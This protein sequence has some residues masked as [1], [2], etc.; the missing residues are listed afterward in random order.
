MKLIRVAVDNRNAKGEENCAILQP[1]SRILILECPPGEE[2]ENQ[3]YERVSEL[4][5]TQK[6]LDGGNLLER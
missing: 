3:K 5:R 1:L 6:K 2:R 4:I